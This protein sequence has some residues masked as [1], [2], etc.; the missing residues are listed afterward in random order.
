M[1]DKTHASIVHS[2]SRCADLPNQLA[3]K[4]DAPTNRIH[5]RRVGISNIRLLESR[6][7]DRYGAIRWSTL[8]G[9]MCGS[10]RW[11]YYVKQSVD[12]GVVHRSGHLQSC[13]IAMQNRRFFSIAR[14]RA[15]ACS[16]DTKE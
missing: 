9:A 1:L 8:H 2:N 10:G 12:G 13:G 7:R 3:R 4:E 6:P 15:A 14:W 5:G 16:G 11:G